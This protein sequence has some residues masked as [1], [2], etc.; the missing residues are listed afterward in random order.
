VVD[1]G[2]RLTVRYLCKPRERRSS[3]SEFWEA[4]LESFAGMPGV[5]LAY[6][7][8]RFYDNRTEGKGTATGAGAGAGAKGAT[9]LEREP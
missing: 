7:T 6:P 8:T 9:S 5:D 2:V 1:S 4:I 3:A